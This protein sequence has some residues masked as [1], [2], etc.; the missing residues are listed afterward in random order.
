MALA[1]SSNLSQSV[2]YTLL[3]T[4]SLKRFGTELSLQ[5]VQVLALTGFRAAQ[6]LCIPASG[7]AEWDSPGCLFCLLS[8]E[9]LNLHSSFQLVLLNSHSELI[10]TIKKE[11]IWKTKLVCSPSLLRR[12][13]RGQ[14]TPGKVSWE[15]EGSPRSQCQ[16]RAPCKTARNRNTKGMHVLHLSYTVYEQF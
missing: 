11:K 1:I 14:E 4:R 7:R 6:G 13:R 5:S 16:E 3:Y 15:A 2:L 10:A 12:V 8:L 9:I